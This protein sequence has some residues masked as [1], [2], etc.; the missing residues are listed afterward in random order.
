MRPEFKEINLIKSLANI[1]GIRKNYKKYVNNSK[2]NIM[3][4]NLK[5]ELNTYIRKYF[6]GNTIKHKKD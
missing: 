5:S 6:D 2:L 4:I 3:G 1:I